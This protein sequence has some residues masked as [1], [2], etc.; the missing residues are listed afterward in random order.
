MQARRVESA[1]DSG[2]RARLHYGWI[3][4]GVIFV[5]LLISAAVR[6]T[7]GAIMVPIEREFG[8]KRDSIAAA[9]ALGLFLFG[10]AG[11]FSGRWIDRFGLRS[12]TLVS[13][14]L[15]SGG[16]LATIFMSSLWEFYLLWGVITGLGTGGASTVLAAAVANRWFIKRR[17]LVTGIL[18]SSSS[19]GLLVFVPL[20]VWLTENYGWRA[21]V[22]S[23]AITGLAMVPF[24]L[25]LLRDSPAAAGVRPYGAETQTVAEQAAAAAEQIVP[26]SVV[27][28]S[29]D[30]WLLCGTFFI[31]GST[32]IGLV[33]THL[34]PFAIDQGISPQV[35]AVAFGVMGLSNFLGAMASGSLSDRYDP[36]YLLFVYYTMR[37][38]TLIALP[39]IAGPVGLFGFVLLS[40]LNYVTTVPT[41]SVLA[42]DIFGKRSV[43]T[44]F[45]WISF[46]HQVGAATMSYVAGAIYVY[47]GSYTGAFMLGGA[48]ALGAGMLSLR[49]R[50]SRAQRAAAAA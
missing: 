20:I 16:A 14:L 31:C 48:L 47:T 45:G 36:R 26:M 11:P 42:A 44:V 46:S 27:M 7:P 13:V 1:T 23:L 34:I 6:S 33:G 3:I 9:V 15:L 32:T 29:G 41:T 22:L 2:S 39:M 24:I 38:L 17:G 40:G 35:A 12:V 10:L 30:F 8:W 49:M 25:L 43:G 37:G 50:Y 19:A 21:G 4:V 5:V 28:Q 18:I